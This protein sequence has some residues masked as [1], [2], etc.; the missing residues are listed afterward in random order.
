MQ[1]KAPDNTVE[2]TNQLLEQIAYHLQRID[3]ASKALVG[4]V[5]FPTRNA[6]DTMPSYETE[7]RVADE[8][9]RIET[10]IEEIMEGR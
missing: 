3:R 7:N 8:G 9:R 10:M 2:R 1:K 4:R 5:I 6:F